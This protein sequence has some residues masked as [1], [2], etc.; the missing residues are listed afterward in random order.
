VPAD[1]GDDF[2]NFEGQ[3][4]GLGHTDDLRQRIAGA[5]HHG[6]LAESVNAFVVQFRDDDFAVAREDF[7][8]TIR[9]GM[10]MAQV[11]VPGFHS[12]VLDAGE[13]FPRRTPA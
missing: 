6:E 5:Q 12:G 2:T 11:D 3:A 4:V 7:L 13:C 8:E 10:K 9:Q 1:A